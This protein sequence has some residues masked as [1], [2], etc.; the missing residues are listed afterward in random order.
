MEPEIDGDLVIAGAA[1]ADPGDGVLGVLPAVVAVL[2]GTPA[3]APAARGP[4]ATGVV[5]LVVGLVAGLVLLVA[6]LALGVPVAGLATPAATAT[7][8]AT[9]TALALLAVL[10]GRSSDWPD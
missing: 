3:P 8:T 7:A 1:L 5:L 2:A 6:R 10:A 4:L 9:G